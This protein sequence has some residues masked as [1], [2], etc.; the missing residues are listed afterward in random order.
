MAT[1]AHDRDA[2]LRAIADWPINAQIALAQAILERVMTARTPPAVGDATGESMPQSTW[3]A[4]YGI[5]S[6]GPGAAH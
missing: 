6:D 4:L 1:A 3:D 2:I 5:A